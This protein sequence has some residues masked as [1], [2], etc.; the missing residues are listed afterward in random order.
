MA[1]AKAKI[2]DVAA[3]AGVSIKTVSRVMNREPNVR[4]GTRER[5]LAASAALGYEPNPAARGLASR[6]SF[7]LGL[8]YENP[9]EFSYTQ[10]A[11]DGVFASCTAAGYTL[12]LLP[13]GEDDTSSAADSALHLAIQARVD[14]VIL[15]A[16][17]CDERRLLDALQERDTPSARIAAAAPD[18]LAC[19]VRAGDRDAARA[20]AEH[21]LELGH[22]RIA[23]IKGDPRHG[24][25]NERFAGFRQALAAR[26]V[27]LDAT[28]VA[29]GLFD[30][31]SGRRAA[32]GLLSLPHRPTAI[33]AS[34]DDMAAG[35]IAAAH[36]LGL[37]VPTAV[38]VAGFDDSPIA[39]RTWPPL[40]T[41]RQPVFEMAA[42]VTD[43]LIASLRGQCDEPRHRVFDCPLVLRDSTAPP[44]GSGGR[45]ARTAMK[46]V[47]VSA[48]RHV[49][50]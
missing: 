19:T 41:V 30:F 47:N 7:S 33:F 49:Q 25:S 29:E 45:L 21:L 26:D 11:F 38:S 22:Q 20:V 15:T 24:A 9:H 28:L 18:G 40:T 14:G 34:N 37:A 3:R 16:P 50:G 5:V 8:L 2:T 43:D 31:D 36:A 12:L 39:S 27:P 17:L 48:D 42:A 4:A 35:A 1:T 32:L 44:P 10:R 46:H 13:C 6:R 23:F